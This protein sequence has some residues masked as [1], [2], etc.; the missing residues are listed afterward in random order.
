MINPVWNPFSRYADKMEKKLDRLLRRVALMGIFAAQEKI[1]ALMQE[2]LVIVN[3]W[4]EAKFK[5]YKYLSRGRRKKMY[6]NAEKI[7]A[8]FL[9]FANATP[10]D[11][12][13]VKAKLSSL[14][15]AMPGVPGDDGKLLLL[16]QIMEFLRPHAGRFEYLEGASFGK[17]LTDPARGEKM[18]GDCN[19]IV[20]FYAYLFSRKYPLQDLQ[21]KLLPGHVCLHFKG[22]DIEATAGTFAKYSQDEARVLP[23]V[24]LIATNLLDVSDFRDKQIQVEP[25]EFL[26]G[27]QLAFNLSSDRELVSKNLKAAYHNVAVESLK[28]KQ[29]ETAVFFL[30]KAGL[31]SP[32]E[33]QTLQTVYHNAVLYYVKEHSFSKARNYA[34]KSSETDLRKYV[35]ERE[36]QYFYEQGSLAKARQ[37]FERAGNRQMIKACYAKEYNALQSRVAGLRDL[38]TMRAHKSD[39]QK[40]LDLAVKMEDQAL[41]ENLRRVIG[42]L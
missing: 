23:I 26:R 41:A 35:D 13:R 28:A 34:G 21:I 31:D 37:L 19:Q 14:G 1:L 5:G 20:T 42:Q 39:Y 32:D 24:E 33:V 4:L 9:T 16:T 3:L 17:L 6:A 10:I 22:I 36:A 12:Q 27:A 18:I 30:Q 25:R 8:A 40:M 11:L 15:L 2:H 29:F 7:A 38:T